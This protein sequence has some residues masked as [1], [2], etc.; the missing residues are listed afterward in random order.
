MIQLAIPDFGTAF[1]L[2]FARIGTLVMLLPGLGERLVPGRVRLTIALGLSLVLLPLVRTLLPDVRDPSAAVG[3]LTGEVLTGLVLGLSARMVM[4]ALQTAGNIVA[5]QLGL[6]FAMT[7]DPT[8]GGGQ[9]AAIGNFISLLGV[10]LILVA[11]VHHLAI[12]AI[13]D[14]YGFMPPA[15]V[16]E[17]GDAAKLA[18]GA[19]ARGFSLAIRISA[20]FIAFGLVFNLAMGVLSRFMPQLQVY[21]LAMPATILVGLLV[22]LSV[23]G[24]MM[25]VFVAD[26]GR[27][28]TDFG[29]R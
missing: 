22:M 20:P 2:T 7:L 14:S 13:R 26:I 24:I 18:I 5:G 6:S 25:S 3:V 16:P 21:F 11:D 27:F 28:L 1:M 15:G 17:T 4:A 23:L 9:E 29:L 10:T 19:V 12:A 8:Q